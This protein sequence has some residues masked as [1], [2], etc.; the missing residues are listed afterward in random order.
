[1]SDFRKEVQK[2]VVVGAS[3]FGRECLDVLEAMISSGKNLEILGV[4]DDFPSEE[5]LDRLKVRG[6]NY[7]GNVDAFLMRVGPG[8]QYL[9]GIGSPSI[10]KHIVEKFNSA[11]IQPFT[12]IHPRSSIGSQAAIG[13]GSVVCSGV[14]ISTNVTTGRHVHL[15]PCAIVGHD[16]VLKDFVSVNP[17]GVVSGEVIVGEGVLIG[18]TALI[19]QQLHVAQNSVIGAGSVVTKSV[20]SSVVVK[21][22][23]GRWIPS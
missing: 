6:I 12:A 13:P 14:T 9:V 16:S 23:P 22:I 21:G 19:L 17:G 11:G 5:N 20:P 10:R 1:M 2:V 7:L 4:L 18:A 3:G 8:I 15:N